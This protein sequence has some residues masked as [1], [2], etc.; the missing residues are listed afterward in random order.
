MT[1]TCALNDKIKQS[2][3]IPFRV[4]NGS[5]LDDFLHLKTQTK[6]NIIKIYIY[7]YIYKNEKKGKIKDSRRI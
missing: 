2:L 6:K 4:C 1:A 3:N 5:K 7:I